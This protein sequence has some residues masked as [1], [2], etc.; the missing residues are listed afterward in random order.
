MDSVENSVM[1][2]HSAIKQ[3]TRNLRVGKFRLQDSPNGV[4]IRPGLG[5]I[6]W[7]IALKKLQSAGVRV[8]VLMHSRLPKL[9]AEADLDTVFR[10][11]E[12]RVP[13]KRRV[14]VPVTSLSLALLVTVSYVQLPKLNTEK[15]P[16]ESAKVLDSCSL[17]Q[18]EKWLQNQSEKM[19]IEIIF[20]RT[21]GGVVAGELNCNGSKYKYTLDGNTT[22]R[23]LKLEKLDS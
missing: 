11:L 5:A 3:K 22:K 18:I 10:V 19:G 23:V 14:L 16:E 2:K 20:E 9:L 4:V 21:V 8:E 15:V 7:P 1:A 13:R 12:R 6:S 17:T